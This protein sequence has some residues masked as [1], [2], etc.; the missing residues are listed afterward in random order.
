MIASGS[1][2]PHRLLEIALD[3]VALAVDNAPRQ[4]FEERE[5]HE[6]LRL[7]HLHAIEGLHELRERRWAA[8]VDEVQ[9]QFPLGVTDPIH[10]QD[11]G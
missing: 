8:I 3:A 5:A 9:R 11:L 1:F 4:A 6:L 7:P 2:S 10:G